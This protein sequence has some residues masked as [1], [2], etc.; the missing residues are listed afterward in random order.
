MTA[1]IGALSSALIFTIGQGKTDLA[2]QWMAGGLYGRGWEQI[3]Y[4]L[5]WFIATL[6]FVALVFVPLKWVRYD[7]SV[8]RGIGIKGP[9]LRMLLLFGTALITA[10]AV[11]AVGPIG[12][13]GLVIPH[14]ARM[15]TNNEPL[16]SLL[17]LCCLVAPFLQALIGLQEPYSFPRRS[18]QA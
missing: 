7:D 10:P 2:L 14:M 1:I 16:H 8:L 4:L 18:L 6:I 17:T 15:L 3:G 11:S 13:V 5:P 12:F 9:T